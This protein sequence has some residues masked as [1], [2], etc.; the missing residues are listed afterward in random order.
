MPWLYV[1]DD[2]KEFAKFNRSL[3]LK[4]HLWSFKIR[5]TPGPRIMQI[6]LVRYSTGVRFGKSLEIFSLCEFIQLLH[7]IHLV[8]DD[9]KEFA[10]FNRSLHLKVHS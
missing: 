10:K 3:H 9:D 2:D 4:V 8:N 1:N 5:F 6:H 7:T